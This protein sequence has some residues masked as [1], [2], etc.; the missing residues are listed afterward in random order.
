MSFG[1]TTELATNPNRCRIGIDVGGTF[2]DF[3]LA[4]ME[5]AEFTRYKQPSVPS[6]PSMTIE[7]GLP[8][9]LERAGVQ[10]SDV[11]LIVH[12][13]TL[14]LNAIIQR[15]G[16]KVGLVVS[17]GNRGILEIGRAKLPNTY[18]NRVK[19]EEA[20]VPRDLIIETS[21]RQTAG[22]AVIAQADDA[23]IAD[24][25]SRLR[26]AGVEAVTV[27]LL[28][29][30]AHPQLEEEFCA[31]LRKALPEIPVS[32]SAGIWPERRE[33]ERSLIAIMN[34]YVQPLVETYMDRLTKRVAAAGISA[35]VYIT[36]SNGG[37]LG[38]ETARTRPIETILSGPASGVVAASRA[39]EQT[40]HRRLITI[41]MG[42][43]SCDVAVTQSGEA[44]YTTSTHVGGLPLI[45]PVVDVSAI[46][47]GGGSIIWVDSQGVIKVGPRSAGGDPGPVC[48]G[49]GG[50][51]PT[52]TDCYLALGFIDP[53]R[54]LGGRM[55][56]DV[57]ASRKALE[58]I[59]EKIGITGE[60]AAERTA[61]AALRVTTAVMS[62][63]LYNNLA[64]RGQ[65][66]REFAL[67]AFGGAGP[68]HANM[69]ANEARIGT[70]II[71]P[72]SATFCALGA[73]LADVKR[74]YVRSI[75]LKL[76]EGRATLDYL[77][78][79]FDDLET[80][81]R[82]WIR[83]EGDLLGEPVF[84]VSCDM[85][86]EGQAF[87]LSVRLPED[88]RRKPDAERL[89]ELF[90]IEHE[91]IY[92]FRDSDSN[93]EITTERVQVIGRIPP[94]AFPTSSEGGERVEPGAWRE[95]FHAG[96]Q[97][98]VPVYARRDLAMGNRIEG[99]AIIEQDDCT[100]WI[101]AGSTVTV[102]GTANLIVQ[103]GHARG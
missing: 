103:T 20:L 40:D 18:D 85:R 86:Y 7:R 71:P 78:S 63:E 102:D 57:A 62:T 35:P 43:T 56:L 91:K 28:H 60:L 52:V 65:D 59:G 88:L 55:K 25:A 66:P 2:T 9:L 92:G 49:M 26:A 48:Y 39:I 24:I 98:R 53:K 61:E 13:T 101:I 37:T 41:D 32:G 54:F 50:A 3:V 8:V 75:H 12:G 64:K 23:E 16:A 10:P 42:G 73:I 79:I 70:V 69:L 19:K 51:E 5:S 84:A 27:V 33:F 1:E 72:A 22:G 44:E 21:A 95:V 87:D 94:I 90:H 4:K 11:E 68:T 29:S 14:A 96:K 80:R 81:A 30:Y 58:A 93:A 74:D 36:A 100:I 34:A 89:R 38:I 47:A 46:G 15:R 45:L 67:M 82:D 83:N 77:K 99:P 17:K 97:A 76:A 31:R 6:D